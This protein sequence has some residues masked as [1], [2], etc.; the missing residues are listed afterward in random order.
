VAH[1]RIDRDLIAGFAG[2][3]LELAAECAE[4]HPQAT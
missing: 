1:D 4:I 3:N 2:H